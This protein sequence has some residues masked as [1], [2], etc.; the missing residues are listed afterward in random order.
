MNGRQERAFGLESLNKG[1]GEDDED[2]EEEDIK[3]KLNGGIVR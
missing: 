1:E 2:E 3:T